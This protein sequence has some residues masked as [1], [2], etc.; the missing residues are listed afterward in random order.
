MSV[1]KTIQSID[2]AVCILDAIAQ[3]EG[4]MTLSEL[5]RELE[6]PLPTLH[7]FIRSL[8]KWDLVFKTSEKGRY[9][10]GSRILQLAGCC[11]RE[12]TL[13]GLIHPHLVQLSEKY[14]ETVHMAVPTEHGILYLDKVECQRPF[15]MTSMVGV[16]EKFSDSAIGLVL[17]ANRRDIPWTEAE[18]KIIEAAGDGMTASL[19]HRDV[20]IH[21]LAAALFHRSGEVQAGISI[22]IPER[23]FTPE[24]RTSVFNDL[25]EVAETIRQRS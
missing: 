12:R 6:M 21:C 5:G 8:E 18:R 19:Y 1:M 9:F 13:I 17:A 10:L 23:R 24:L 14:E 20:G 22:A 2:K 15:R 4:G 11:D 16:R 3:K 25:L 7:G